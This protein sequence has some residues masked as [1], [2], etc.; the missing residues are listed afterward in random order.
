[1]VGVSISPF[2]RCAVLCCVSAGVEFAF[3]VCFEGLTCVKI[4]AEKALEFL[5]NCKTGHPEKINSVL[6][7]CPVWPRVACLLVGLNL[8]FLPPLLLTLSL[9]PLF[10]L[11]NPPPSLFS[12]SS[13]PLL[14]SPFPHP[15]FSPFVHNVVY[16]LNTRSITERILGFF[17]L[18]VI[19]YR[20]S[21][22]ATL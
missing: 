20:T 6:L 10:S 7:L 9:F 16:Q 11:S 21:S 1:M 13:L 2:V 3:L 8:L 5:S 18:C 19:L 22:R 15:P 14:P 12:P 17:A 4:L